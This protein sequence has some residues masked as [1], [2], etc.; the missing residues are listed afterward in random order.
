MWRVGP[1]GIWGRGSH[2]RPVAPGHRPPHRGLTVGPGLKLVRSHTGDVLSLDYTPTASGQPI[3]VKITANVG[4]AVWSSAGPS[5]WGSGLCRVVL[6][7]NR[8]DGEETLLSAWP[9][10]VVAPRAGYA[11]RDDS[12]QLWLL[13]ASCSTVP[14]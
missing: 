1:A 3:P 14:A 8:L 4:A 10:G 6:G 13:E 11:T 9:D 7:L 12:G 5:A 2:G